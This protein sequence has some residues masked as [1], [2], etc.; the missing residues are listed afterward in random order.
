M[1]IPA[2][3]YRAL[4]L[5]SLLAILCTADPAGAVPGAPPPA[6]DSIGRALK[7]LKTRR[8]LCALV[9]RDPRVD[10]MELADT[11]LAQTGMF[12]HVMA[13]T[14]AGRDALRRV[15]ATGHAAD[16][17]TVAQAPAGTRLPYAS[18]LLDLL[19]IVPPPDRPDA[20]FFA[21][22]RR[23]LAPA[24][25]LLVLLP[26]SDRG[27]AV[28]K[29]L[30]STAFEDVQAL[31]D[32]NGW[33]TVSARK[34]KPAGMDDWPQFLHG[35]DNNAVSHDRFIGPPSR[36]Q[37]TAGPQWS[38]DHDVTPSIF[39]LTSAAGRIFYILDRGPICVVDK[40]L[41]GQW[42][43]VARNAFN[44]ALLWQSPLRDWYSNRLIWG[45]IPAS[46]ERRVAATSDRV[47]LTPGL[48]APVTALDAAAG[49]VIHTYAGTKD[50]SEIVLDRDVLVLA[51][52]RTP[53]TE[54]KTV[55]R[56]RRRFRPGFP[57]LASGSRALMAVRVDS[58]AILWR[59]G[60]Q[61]RPLTLAALGDRVV[62]SEKDS[63]VCVDRMTGGE[64]WRV[65]G[66]AETIV[67][68]KDVVLAGAWTDA[69]PGAAYRPRSR[70]ATLRALSLKDG[71]ELWSKQGDYLPTFMFFRVS[72]DVFVTEGDVVWGVGRNLEWN[73]KPGAG[74]LIGL[75][76]Y[77]GAEKV[78][79]DMTGAFTAGHHVRCYKSKAT[80]R[81]LLFNKRGIEFVGTGSGKGS[82]QVRWVRGACRYGIMPANGLI[83][84]PPQACFC[85]PETQLSGF[86]AVSAATSPGTLPVPDTE[87]LE[88][89]PAYGRA[90]A[91]PGV[92]AED[93]PMYR[94]DPK[95]S[96]S[97]PT[98]VPAKLSI[99]WK[100][101][102][103]PGLTPPVCAAGTVYVAQRTSGRLFALS[104][105]T[106]ALLWQFMAGGEIDSPPVLWKDRVLFGC[107]DG[108]VYCLRANTGALAW[109][110]LAARNHR[111]IA[112][113]GR[114]ESAWPVH[115][116]VLLFNGLVY[117]VAG[118]TSETDGGMDV[119]ALDP[120]TG[121]VV[122][123]TRLVGPDE[124]RVRKAGV[125]IL[126]GRMP[127]ARNDILL[128]D[129]N[130]LY[131]R[132][133]PLDPSLPAAVPVKAMTW[134]A[135]GPNHFLATS[136]F[137]DDTFFN[138]SVWQYGAYVHRSQMLTFDDRAVYGVRVYSGISWNCP[139]WNVGDGYLLFRRPYRPPQQ[140]PGGVPAPKG[141]RML[142][143]VPHE[144]FSWSR[145]VHV[146]VRGLVRTG[147]TPGSG[148]LFAAG[149]PERIDPKD[150]TAAFEQRTAGRLLALDAQ[151]GEVRGDIRIPA[152]PVFDGLIA[153]R[154]R[155][156][157]SL[158]NGQVACLGRGP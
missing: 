58:G 62:F 122:H 85:Y 78:R 102:L 37:W 67:L 20:A 52:R 53:S 146:L 133:V 60:F 86:F 54:G 8:G 89:G 139:I 19:T 157:L 116:S 11:L 131:L 96:G 70:R 141:K 147:R 84:G 90:V 105:D 39:G 45:H 91:A 56:D 71:R 156:I 108:R 79:R 22:C 64:R 83:Y 99:L 34:S 140:K 127:G 21:E 93:W 15:I 33:W 134:G 49:R 50:T 88:P 152:P 94:H 77:T 10:G 1:T 27:D 29:T 98:D 46:S 13:P 123:H 150:P 80:D 30:R 72:M 25:T 120:A 32:H 101:A 97:C 42:V 125:R 154:G 81:F 129:G 115:G 2:A 137:L 31:R 44:G 43:L 135:K 103:G 9:V 130:R 109:S 68:Y 153:A 14:P 69:P 107:R 74:A 57:G 4:V 16:R 5:G 149:A 23:V 36:V 119:V 121:R 87:R 63:V 82:V 111:T 3:K 113:E 12:V 38:R 55:S 24:G 28:T 112:R 144:L 117:A 65:P 151:T 114:P 148:T 136:G 6:T 126:S 124:K 143:R 17:V 75:D 76:L 41:P 7:P 104:A 106:G 18:N 47:F 59:K 100:Q 155:L 128:T 92:S 40:R 158:R 51:I 35:P 145:T 66:Q 48:G 73:K 132:H 138:R 142:F 26:G 110:Y 118:R 61:A 95:R